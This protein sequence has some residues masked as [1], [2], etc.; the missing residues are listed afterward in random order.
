MSSKTLLVCIFCS[1]VAGTGMA[2]ETTRQTIQLSFPKDT[3]EE[4]IRTNLDQIGIILDEEST[5][6]IHEEQNHI[7]LTCFNC[8]VRNINSEN[9][10]HGSRNEEVF[11]R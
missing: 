3:T 11:S 10:V 4:N 1:L 2:A 9:L 7:D 5:I 8:I 6:T